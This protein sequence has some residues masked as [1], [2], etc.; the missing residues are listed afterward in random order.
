MKTSLYHP[1][2][3]GLAERALRIFQEGMKKMDKGTG[4]LMTKLQRFLLNYRT[5]PQTRT[6]VAPAELLMNRKLRTTLDF[7]KPKIRKRVGKRQKNFK[8]YHDFHARKRT[9]G[10]GETVIV[11]NLEDGNAEKLLRRPDRY[12][13]K[14]H[15]QMELPPVDMLITSNSGISYRPYS[16]TIQTK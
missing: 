8:Q 12:L 6:G 10:E 9:F 15:Y 16:W 14:L 5:T 1:A 7:V 4:S 2:S 3:N 13:I 11:K